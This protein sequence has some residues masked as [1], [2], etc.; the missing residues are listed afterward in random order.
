MSRLL[1]IAEGQTEE[2]FLKE[3]VFPYFYDKGL[4]DISVSILPS[5][6]T[7]SGK[8]HK[9]GFV[10]SKKILKYANK[11][12]YSGYVTTFLDYYGIDEDFVGY[13]DSLVL[14]TIKEKKECL[15]HALKNDLSSDLFIPYIQMHEFEGLLFSNLDSFLFVE[16][17]KEKLEILKSEISLFNTPEHV[18]NSRITAPSKR[19]KRIY[20]SYGK[21]S[22]GILVAEDIGINKILSECSLFNEWIEKIEKI[23]RK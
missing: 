21:V 12:L 8:R 22:D 3:I 14:R 23:L 10:T 9:G 20:P 19:I 4:Y 13:Q 5:K 15:E 17:D 7:A 6:T 1:I 18:N 16:D 11:L 2:K